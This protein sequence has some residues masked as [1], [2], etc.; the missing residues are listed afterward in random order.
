MDI[1]VR[2]IWMSVVILDFSFS[3]IYRNIF[4]IKENDTILLYPGKDAVDIRDLL[5]VSKNG[6]P[7]TL[8]LIDGTWS[9]AKSLYHNSPYLQQ[10]R[11]VLT[12]LNLYWLLSVI[13]DLVLE[14]CVN[15]PLCSSDPIWS[16][17]IET[18]APHQQTE[19]VRTNGRQRK[20]SGQKNVT[21]KVR[22]TNR[23]P[24]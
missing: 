5:P 2:K 16:M 24:N 20:T 9:Q 12:L 8:L 18:L 17:D 3:Y 13:R 23:S 4:E 11:Q 15:E 14:T 1:F 22:V 6:K 19:G 21:K 10:L 7:Y